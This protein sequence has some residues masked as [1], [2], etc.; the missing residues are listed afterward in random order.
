[1]LRRTHR[2]LFALWTAFAIGCADSVVGTNSKPPPDPPVVE[3]LTPVEVSGIVARVVEPAPRVVV[4]DRAGRPMPGIRLLF[5]T[6]GGGTVLPA[7][8]EV[9]TDNL[10]VAELGEWRLPTTAGT[11]VLVVFVANRRVTHFT[12][13]ARPDIPAAVSISRQPEI[14]FPSLPLKLTATVTDQFG[15]VVDGAPVAFSVT[16]GGGSLSRAEATG[17]ALAAAETQ[18]TLGHFGLNTLRASSA[19]VE[20]S[21]SV[22]VLDPA[23]FTFYDLLSINDN[24]NSQILS[25]SWIALGE[26]GHFL[27]FME[28]RTG[29]GT[30]LAGSYL[31]FPRGSSGFTLVLTDQMLIDCQEYGGVDG[32]ILYIDRRPFWDCD[33]EWSPTR[34][35]YRRRGAQTP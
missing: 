24:Y 16:A 22:T 10:G 12:A 27:N 5:F 34:W 15:N 19:G 21:I 30:L 20:H 13:Q 18:W 9:L 2:A 11:S 33:P 3:A 4:K 29:G 17:S 1:M 26:G 14:G 6:E 7:G 25:G 35:S 32:D 31:L 28:F 23:A 8:G